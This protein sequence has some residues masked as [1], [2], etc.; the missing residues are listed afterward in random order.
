MRAGAVQNA[1][2]YQGL[3]VRCGEATSCFT[4]RVRA[5][6]VHNV[7]FCKGFRCV[8]VRLCRVSG[9]RQRRSGAKSL[10]LQGFRCVQVSG[11]WDFIII[12]N[13]S[14]HLNAPETLAGRSGAA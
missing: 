8:E 5:G 6:A 1:V 14:P 2:V 9:S 7:A 10:F 12:K 4:R 3:V 11:S 13:T